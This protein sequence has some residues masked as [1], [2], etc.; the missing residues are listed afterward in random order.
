MFVQIR[1]LLSGS[2]CDKTG[3]LFVGDCLVS[4]NDKDLR[5]LSHTAVLQELK[6]PRTHVTLVILR[7]KSLS[8]SKTPSGKVLSEDTTNHVGS[9]QS[10]NQSRVS[11]PPAAV[12]PPL[13][14]SSPPPMSDDEEQIYKQHELDSL[15]DETVERA[16]VSSGSQFHPITESVTPQPKGRTSDF[17]KHRF[18]PTPRESSAFIP[19]N[20]EDAK[21]ESNVRTYVSPPPI[22]EGLT[23]DQPVQLTSDASSLVPPPFVFVED[24]ETGDF[25]RQPSF[26]KYILKPPPMVEDETPVATI[27]EQNKVPPP[28]VLSLN[29]NDYSK[30]DT[31]EKEGTLATVHSYVLPP[32]L[33]SVSAQDIYPTPPNS[34][35]VP[36]TSSVQLSDSPLPSTSIPSPPGYDENKPEATLQILPPPPLKNSESFPSIVPPPPEM[37]SLPTTTPAT[38]AHSQDDPKSDFEVVFP[39]PP[40]TTTTTPLS[41]TI[42]SS[43]PT[44]EP[45]T[46]F[47]SPPPKQQSS[48]QRFVM[49][50]PPSFVPP[51]PGHSTLPTSS[52]SKPFGPISSRSSSTPSPTLDIC[53]PPPPLVDETPTPPSPPTKLHRTEQSISK[54]LKPSPLATP[55]THEQT[56]SSSPSS[57]E[58]KPYALASSPPHVETSV[59]GTYPPVPQRES[60]IKSPQVPQQEKS[61]N[62]ISP[63]NSAICLLDEI[64]ESQT[65]DSSSSS[66]AKSVDVTTVNGIE[67]NPEALQAPKLGN[68]D[69]DV[70]SAELPCEKHH[71]SRSSFLSKMVVGQR[72]EEHPFMIEYQLKKSKG[73]GIKLN[74]S[75]DGRIVVVELS[76]SGVVKKDG[77]IR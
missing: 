41:P 18:F 47:V 15:L 45:P 25:Q 1:R 73:L 77:H 53:P 4:V 44:V 31:P 16:P 70:V 38:L 26:S 14:S 72:S 65:A 9:A 34:P 61:T 68:T 7:E 10:K 51:P 66:D 8:Q 3:N 48:T 74:S 30:E 33:S 27:I 71:G 69:R 54:V 59:A 60:K 20:H 56:S 39:P 24:N 49:P 67:T 52:F 12:P 75:A 50:P 37:D 6:K 57:K 36:A 40:S 21:I 32:P 76:G 46:D 42:A 5:E 13:P 43:S 64:L 11:S 29:N 23:M 17:N 28:M 2:V 55:F 62:R 63:S 35:P 19:P 22:N 58:H